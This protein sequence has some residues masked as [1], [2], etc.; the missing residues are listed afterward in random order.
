MTAICCRKFILFLFFA[1]II[2]HRPLPLSR[3][4]KISAAFGLGFINLTINTVSF[5]K[6]L[7]GIKPL[8]L[9]FSRTKILFGILY[10]GNSLRNDQFGRTGNFM[11]KGFSYFGISCRIY[12]TGRVV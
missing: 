2:E 3:M 10:A 12:C 1:A 5:K 7:M 9:P 11:G 4:I 8:I 6:T